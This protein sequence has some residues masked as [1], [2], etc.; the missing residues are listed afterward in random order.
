[1]SHAALALLE[2][3]ET[4]SSRVVLSASSVSFSIRCNTLFSAFYRAPKVQHL[5]RTYLLAL[6]RA[7]RFLVQSSVRRV[8]CFSHFLQIL[9]S[10][11]FVTSC[12]PIHDPSPDHTLKRTDFL[13]IQAADVTECTF[14][15]RKQQI[16]TSNHLNL[17][18]CVHCSDVEPCAVIC[19]EVI[20]PTAAEQEK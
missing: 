13:F 5:F 10:Y 18:L 15:L 9:Y 11:S 16:L 17:L 19:W 2:L 7:P 1:M 20:A 4:N 12:F 3:T 14:A 8:N 6:L